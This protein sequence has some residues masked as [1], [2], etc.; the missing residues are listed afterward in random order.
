VE[1]EVE[2][3]VE[4]PN[5]TPISRGVNVGV[6]VDRIV[7]SIGV[8]LYECCVCGDTAYRC[9][10]CNDGHAVCGGCFER[11]PKL[12]CPMCRS[13]EIKRNK[14]VE[15]VLGAASTS[16]CPHAYCEFRALP[17]DMPDHIENCPKKECPCPYCRKTTTPIDLGT[18]LEYECKNGPFVT[19]SGTP[20]ITSAINTFDQL[21]IQ[22]G[23]SERFTLCFYFNPERKEFEVVCTQ[24]DDIDQD[25]EYVVLTVNDGKQTFRI[26]IHTPSQFGDMKVTR[27][28]SEHLRRRNSVTVSG[29]HQKYQVGQVWQVNDGEKWVRGK[30]IKRLYFPEHVCFEV[31]QDPWRVCIDLK[32]GDSELIR[33]NNVRTTAEEVV[34]AMRSDANALEIAL[35]RSIERPGDGV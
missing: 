22:S 11:L 14:L 32:E 29:M 13:P 4:A 21:I 24:G 20:N 5:L 10:A 18:H 7:V 2:A 8:N 23:M 35:A 6:R 34:Y 16:R 9:Y 1:A 12:E 17:S 27:I 33:Q 3:E 30:V 19:V 26:P 15:L 31:K 25:V 28:N